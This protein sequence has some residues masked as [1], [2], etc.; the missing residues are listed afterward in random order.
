MRIAW[1]LIQCFLNLLYIRITMEKAM[2]PHSSTLA[3]RIPGMAEPGGLQSMGSHGVGHDWSDLAAAAAESLCDLLHIAKLR[4]HP[5][6]LNDIS[7]RW[8]GSETQYFFKFPRD[9]KEQKGL[10]TNWAL[11]SYIMDITLKLGFTLLKINPSQFKYFHIIILSKY[12]P[13]NYWVEVI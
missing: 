13:N 10:G 5:R 1:K 11:L 7:S 12:I 8:M 3:W 4:S 2:A 6:Q 9:C